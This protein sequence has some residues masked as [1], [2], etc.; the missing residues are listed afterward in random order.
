MRRTIVL[1]ALLLMTITTFGQFGAPRQTYYKEIDASELVASDSVYFYEDD[2][3]RVPFK[4][5][6]GNIAVEVEYYG[7]DANDA[8]VDIG[9]SNF[10]YSFNSL[11]TAKLPLLL[12]LQ[13]DSLLVNGV[14]KGQTAGVTATKIWQ[15][16]LPVPFKYLGLKLTLNSVSSG[17]IKI[18]IYQY[19]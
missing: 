2:N 6:G 5:F 4:I 10:G 11:D 13:N 9:V 1:V 19:E 7:V 16:T 17:T 8:T 3:Q 14:I 18:W 15:S 12:D